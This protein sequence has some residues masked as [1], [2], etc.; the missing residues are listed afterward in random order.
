MAVEKNPR[1]RKMG[2]TVNGEMHK[3]KVLEVGFVE[4]LDEEERGLFSAVAKIRGG[5]G[6]RN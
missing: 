1:V 4:Q 6:N 5:K 2:K 3:K